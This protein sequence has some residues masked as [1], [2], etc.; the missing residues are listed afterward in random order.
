ML[1]HLIDDGQVEI[2]PLSHMRGRSIRNSIV[3]CDE[4]EN[5]NDKLVTL[6]LSRI[7]EDSEIIFCGDVAQIDDKRFEKNNGIQA[8]ISSLAGD[9]LF[10]MVKL[11]KS[12]RGRVPKLCDLIIPPK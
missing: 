7:E 12:E 11:I 9:P 4:C 2:Y 1:D 6:L 3:L 10:G 8:M 5:L